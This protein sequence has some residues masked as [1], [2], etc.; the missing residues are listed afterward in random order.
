MGLRSLFYVAFALGFGFSLIYLALMHRFIA[1][2]RSDPVAAERYPVPLHTGLLD[3]GIT[4]SLQV[5]SAIV[6]I[7]FRR[8][9]SHA[10][11][12]LAAI[13]FF[14]LCAVALIFLV[15]LGMFFWAGPES[16]SIRIN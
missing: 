3:S 15:C 4:Q 11:R 13:Q 2:W 14:F 8:D 12:T 9:V 10:L 5:T 16:L 1:A 6:R 7:A